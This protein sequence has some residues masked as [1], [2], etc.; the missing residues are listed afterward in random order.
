M[1]D[2]GTCSRTQKTTRRRWWSWPVTGITGSRWIRRRAPLPDLEWYSWRSRRGWLDDG[3]VRHGDETCW[4]RTLDILPHVQSRLGKLERDARSIR[5]VAIHTHQP[6]RSSGARARSW[7]RRSL[8]GCG[9][10]TGTPC[11]FMQQRE[12][13]PY[14]IDDIFDDD[15]IA[16]GLICSSRDNYLIL[17]HDD[18]DHDERPAAGLL[19]DR[20][21]FHPGR[22]R[23][24]RAV[25]GRRSSQEHQK[26]RH[27]L[28][29]ITDD[30]SSL[31]HTGGGDEMLI[32][33]NIIGALDSLML[34]TDDSDATND[35]QNWWTAHNAL[36][37]ISD[38]PLCELIDLPWSFRSIQGARAPHR[39]ARHVQGSYG[40]WFIYARC[41]FRAAWPTMIEI[42]WW[43]SIAPALTI[44]AHKNTAPP[45]R[46]ERSHSEQAIC[47]L[48]RHG[49]TGISYHQRY[50]ARYRQ[51]WDIQNGD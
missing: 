23:H 49:R 43:R 33:D 41:P 25:V 14:S 50:R 48:L 18:D 2:P 27:M 4:D 8:G 24:R 21:S 22:R 11:S 34:I 37:L 44:W 47:S 30:Y 7:R 36:T 39:P 42:I 9:A 13:I 3:G 5:W 17:T 6:I 31:N 1:I 35:Q 28:M 46:P 45:P 40:T 15:D 20:I 19:D 12:N 16:H 26:N 51:H 32:D 38:T 29:L 10:A